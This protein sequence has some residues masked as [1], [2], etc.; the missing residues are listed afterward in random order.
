MEGWYD[1]GS[2]TTVGVD[3]WNYLL[4]EGARD[5]FLKWN[6]DLGDN[7]SNSEPITVYSNITIIAEWGTEYY[8]TVHS[9]YGNPIGE[10]W[11]T[12][13]SNVSTRLP[14]NIFEISIL[15]QRMVFV[16]WKGDAT[17]TNYRASTDILMD[18]PKTVSIAWQK[19]FYLRIEIDPSFL[20]D[21]GELLSYE[22]CYNETM[23]VN[24]TLYKIDGY[25]LNHYLLNEQHYPISE[26]SITITMD[27]TLKLVVVYWRIQ[28]ILVIITIIFITVFIGIPVIILKYGPESFNQFIQKIRGTN[29]ERT[30]VE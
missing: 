7:H 17:G 19:Q 8:L 26:I 14:T 4:Y 22:G 21:V 16:R 5:I 30:R 24:I 10:G 28:G 11:R 1:G 12:A 25:V 9:D 27:D 6:Y 23:D 15:A 20:E 2:I 3:I 13:G 18:S 29:L